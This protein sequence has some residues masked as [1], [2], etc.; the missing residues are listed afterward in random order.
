M[1]V[2]VGAPVPD[3]RVGG[4]WMCPGQVLG[5]GDEKVRAAHGVDAIQALQLCLHMLDALVRQLERAEGCQ[6]TWLSM[7]DLGLLSPPKPG[8]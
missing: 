5:L 1:S 2:R 7:P 8:P 4:D 6:T 3:P